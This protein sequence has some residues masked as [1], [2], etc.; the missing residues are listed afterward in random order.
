V[1]HYED[2]GDEAALIEFVDLLNIAGRRSSLGAHFEEATGD[3]RQL[4]YLLFGVVLRVVVVD[5][6]LSFEGRARQVG[7]LLQ[8]LRVLVQVV[9]AEEVVPC[10]SGLL[11]LSVLL[12]LVLR[13]RLEDIH[14]HYLGEKLL[15]LLI[16]CLLLLLGR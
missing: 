9:S 3:Y 2:H 14:V 13:L 5:G 4:G 10:V 1:E 16:E 15:V 12:L 6:V 11:Q 7:V 8:L